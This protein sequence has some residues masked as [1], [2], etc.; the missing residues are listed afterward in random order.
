MGTTSP[1]HR[2]TTINEPG[3]AP[4]AIVSP[5]HMIANTARS[6]RARAGSDRMR[7]AASR[8]VTASMRERRA[9]EPSSSRGHRIVIA[10]CDHAAG[11]VRGMNEAALERVVVAQ[12]NGRWARIRVRGLLG[13]TPLA[14]SLHAQAT[15]AL[16]ARIV[17]NVSTG[18]VRVELD[19]RRDVTFWVAWLNGRLGASATHRTGSAATDAAVALRASVPATKATAPIDAPFT[20][21]AA[22]RGASVEAAVEATG[23]ALR[24]ADV[25]RKVGLPATALHRGL[26]ASEAAARRRRDGPNEIADVTGRSDLAILLDQFRSLPVALLGASAGIAAFTRAFADAAAIG[27]VLVANGGLGFATERRA[28]RTV[29]SL[30]RLAPH[31]ATVMRDG[32]AQVIDARDVVV[33]DLLVLSA[34]DAVAADARVVEAHRLSTNEAA[35]TGESLPVRKAPA[36]DVAPDAPLGERRNMVHMGSVVS[37]GVGLAVVTATAE[38]T[39]LGAIRRL[40]QESDAP[41][42]QLQAQLDALGKRLAIGA[43]VLCGGVFAIGLVRRRPL[44]PLL[45]TTVSLGVAAIPEGLPTVATSLLA[46]AIRTLRER[47][48]YARSLDAVENLGAIDTVCL[49][50]TGTLTQNRMS[51]TAVSAG[52]ALREADDP[53][54]ARLPDAWGR[55]A[56]LCNTLETDEGSG[57]LQG[58]ST[59]LALIEY[60]RHLGTDVERIRAG[61]PLLGMR[62]R[63]EHH[64]YM[65]TLHESAQ[66]G[67]FVAVK[68]RPDA[69]LERCIQ[70]WDGERIVALT[71]RDRRAL[72]A[73]NDRIARRGERVLALACRQHPGRSYGE[74]AGLCWLG[75]VGL[76][77]PL[78]PGIAE[79]IDRFRRAGVRPLMITGDQLGTA[80]AIAHAIGLDGEQAVADAGALPENAGDIADVVER[81][82]GF[83]RSTPA[84]KLE[85]V[86]ALQRRGHVVAMTGDGI[87]DG[88][89][90]KTADVGVA[91]GVSGTD[92][93]HA[94]SDLVLKEDHPA[95]LLSAIEEGRT[96]FI[97]VRKAL[98][99]LV[100]TNLSELAATGVCVAA[101]LPEPFEPLALLWTNLVTDIWP[102]IALGAEPPEPGVLERPPVSLARGV[103][104]PHE[105]RAIGVDA[106]AITAATLASF[107][108]GLARYGP[109]PRARTLAFTT[110][111]SSQLVYALA[112]RSHRPLAAGGLPANPAL[113]RAIALSLA[114]QAGT[115]VFPPLRAVLRT[116]PLGIADLVVAAATSVF[117]LAFRES[118]KMISHD[119][120]R[121]PS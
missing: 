18:S 78:R 35:L 119:G 23:H 74:T 34:G 4:P 9:I 33:G 37:G 112:M 84:M 104:E 66:H 69:V 43:A 90:L 7:A 76:S 16:A 82:S 113:R 31:S 48:V 64:P 29:A 54:R 118:I 47:Q 38:R 57:E 60:A 77:D 11:T 62:D 59:E 96:A 32:A 117:P 63:S 97:N 93:A 19:A 42:T 87:N 1:A 22:R 50:K 21:P 88:P 25:C 6:S 100:A 61:H 95:A 41:H 5:A 111:T 20:A 40:A 3:S 65:V 49:D 89:A 121:S 24:L 55:V 14:A 105:W 51:V 102:A 73:L 98:R 110:L 68:G 70:W 53:S 115:L 106:A 46:R 13:N 81:S 86:R 109:G 39:A 12:A 27:A 72:M 8:D 103:L 56:A 83:A 85:I 17:V 94:M 67:L 2:L 114:A 116:A 44:V 71:L 107:A 101:G 45:R 120:Q 15:P 36:D 92:F 79:M 99:Y 80:G 28:E 26:G 58:S 30:R 10:V 52:F 91:M 108:F 75:M